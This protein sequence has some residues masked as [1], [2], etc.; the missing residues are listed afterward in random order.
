MYFLEK[1]VQT[2]CCLFVIQSCFSKRIFTNNV[3]GYRDTPV[4]L[5]LESPKQECGSF[6]AS[7]VHRAGPVQLGL[8]TKNP[9]LKN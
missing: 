7:P 9:V 8:C 1:G 5:A 3:A 6:E 2:S 4:I